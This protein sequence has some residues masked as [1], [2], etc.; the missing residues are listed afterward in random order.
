[1]TPFACALGLWATNPLGTC[2]HTAGP[3]LTALEKCATTF[4]AVAAPSHS[5]SLPHLLALPVLGNAATQ[6]GQT[7]LHHAATGGHLP[8]INVLLEHHAD[9]EAKSNVCKG[10]LLGCD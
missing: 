9:L 3:A 7:P 8:A 10:W 6:D 2:C 4:R 5:G 1:M